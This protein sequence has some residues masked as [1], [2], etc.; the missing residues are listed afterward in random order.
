VARADLED[1]SLMRLGLSS[2]AA[3]HASLDELATACAARGLSTLELRAGDGHGIDADGDWSLAVADLLAT[4][5]TAGV[6]IAGYSTDALD[7]ADQLAR[8]SQA[9]AAPIL[10]SDGSIGQRIDRVRAITD[11]GGRALVLASGSPAA[12]LPTVRAARLDFGWEVDAAC[13]DV[14]E[15]AASVLKP[16]DAALRYIRFIGGGPETTMQ[17]GM[18]V[19]TLMGTLALAGYD[20]PLVLTPSSTR[21]HVAW[22]TWLGRRGGWGCGSRAASPELVRMPVR[23]ATGGT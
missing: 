9:M 5:A 8:L 21:Y 14:S 23:T 20:R 12:W 4:T 13:G 3:P 2:A 10:V 22:E 6:T 19:G 15:F 16:Q 17:E 18:G 11:A 1:G 7:D